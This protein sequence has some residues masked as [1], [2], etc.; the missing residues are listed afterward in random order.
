M[1]KPRVQVTDHAV[2]RYL[3][4][5]LQMDIEAIRCEIGHRVERGVDRGAS[6]VC[7]DGLRYR[8]VD[9]VVVTVVPVNRPARGKGRPGKRGAR[10]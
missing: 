8:L 5:G 6:A 7:V 4:R 3:E 9:D 1:K 2:L 10:K